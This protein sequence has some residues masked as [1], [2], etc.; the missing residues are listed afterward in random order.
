MKRLNSQHS[1]FS[2]DGQTISKTKKKPKSEIVDE[3]DGIS[4]KKGHNSKFVN[5]EKKDEY[6]LDLFDEQSPH[7][8][9]TYIKFGQINQQID[10][11]KQEKVIITF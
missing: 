3:S 7:I 11:L 2:L 5:F 6:L 10:K 8:K 4:N 1:T 9:P